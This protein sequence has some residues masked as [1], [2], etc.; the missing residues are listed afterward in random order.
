LI[1]YIKIKSKK[2]NHNLNKLSHPL[3]INIHHKEMPSNKN[4]INL[5]NHLKMLNHHL[6]KNLFKWKNKGLLILK[7]SATWKLNLLL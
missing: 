1:K 3:L 5:K 2:S 6:I 4:M 7:K